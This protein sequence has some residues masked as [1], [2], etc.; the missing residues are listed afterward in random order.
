MTS[1]VDYIARGWLILPCHHIERRRCSCGNPRCE[2][3]GKHPRTQHGFYDASSDIRD[4]ESWTRRFPK[5]NWALRTG[6]ETGISVID[7]DPRNG[8]LE[9]FQDLQNT[10]GP[11]PETLRSATGGGGRH[12][13]YLT[14]PGFVM[15][16]VRGWMPGIDIKSNL[17]YVILPE[18]NHKGGM[19]YHWLN[20]ETQAPIQLPPDIARMIRNRP[21]A[22][23][24]GGG[25]SR[26]LASTADILNGVPE[27]ERDDTLFRFACR[28]RRQTDS[29]RLTQL[30]VFDAATNCSP[31]FPM[32]QA[33]RKVDQAW[34]QD[35]SDTIVDWNN[36]TQQM[37]Q[38]ESADRSVRIRLGG[39]FILDEPEIVPAV[40]GTGERVLW[41]EGEG[42]MITGH[43]G[44]GKTTVAQQ[45]VLHRIGLRA[46]GFL[47]LPVTKRPPDL[48]SRDGPTS[49]GSEIVPA[50][51][52]RV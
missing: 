30:A 34:A 38:Q 47:G 12:L 29:Y 1:P 9:S 13:F 25:M 46:G 52:H 32:D 21:A 39:D 18:S 45:L 31:P 22:S 11:M 19:R 28:I 4:I 48:V 37:W 15:P 14:A 35:H 5:A 40:W 16:S 6:P 24:N 17:G 43:Q 27:G 20:W 36:A 26:D 51:D 3:P 23:G 7:I 8:G 2:T 50:D 33:Q 41:A 44:V 10:R 49:A 42:I